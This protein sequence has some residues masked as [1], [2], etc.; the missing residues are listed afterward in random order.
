MGVLILLAAL[1]FSD[2]ADL[3]NI[4]QQNKEFY[5]INYKLQLISEELDR[6]LFYTQ[7]IMKNIDRNKQH[8]IVYIQE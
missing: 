6:L 4:A 5:L 2:E 3:E 7:E 1:T 8:N